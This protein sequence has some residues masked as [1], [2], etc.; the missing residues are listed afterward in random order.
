MNTIQLHPIQNEHIPELQTLFFSCNDY[1]QLVE[2]RGVC[3]C[4]AETEMVTNYGDTPLKRFG[5]F[6]NTM[7][8]GAIFFAEG[9]PREEQVAITILLIH[10]DYRGKGIGEIAVQHIESYALDRGSDSIVVG[11]DTENKQAEKFWM[12]HGY[13]AT[14]E[15]EQYNQIFRN[16]EVHYFEK[17]LVG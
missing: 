6:E 15:T 4:R 9:Y 16:R 5:I 2:G 7:L 13:R 17:K 10:P 1:F 3:G 14:G 11:I 8:I 12:R